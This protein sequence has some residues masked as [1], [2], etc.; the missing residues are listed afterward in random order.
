MMNTATRRSKMVTLAVTRASPFHQR[1]TVATTLS[2]ACCCWDGHNHLSINPTRRH[3]HYYN[4]SLQAT[5]AC[6]FG[7]R[8]VNILSGRGT[9][10]DL[11]IIFHSMLGLVENDDDD[12]G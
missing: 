7:L 9:S 12:G 8:N 2:T 3:A 4:V 6:E 1:R 11:P 10:G 5:A